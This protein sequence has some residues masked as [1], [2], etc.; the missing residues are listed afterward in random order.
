LANYVDNEDFYKALV[1]YKKCVNSA[2][3]KK[4]PRPVIPDFVAEC[5]ML[6]ANRLSMSPC[7]VNYLFREDLVGDAVE[8]C[9]QYIDNFNGKKFKKPFAYFTQICFWAFLRRIHK[10]KK[11]L[12]I[13]YKT[14]QNSLFMEDLLNSN[15]FDEAVAQN[16]DLMDLVQVDAEEPS[17]NLA[18]KVTTNNKIGEFV[19]NFED[20]EGISDRKKRKKK[21]GKRKRKKSRK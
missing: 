13:K 3:R 5:I 9:V 20:K 18:R 8:N 12:Y 6:I 17:S 14:F 11:Q 15:E 10:E 19:K 16:P 21:R 1:Q 2:L 7:F 4:E